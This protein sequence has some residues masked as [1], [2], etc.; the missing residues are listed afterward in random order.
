MK[1]IF[2]T[3]APGSKWS[4]VIKSVYFSPDIDR[5][6]HNV[7]REYLDAE[8]Q[9][10]HFGAYYDPGM[11]FG[12]FFDNLSSFSKQEC[13]NEFDKPFSGTGVR[14]IKSHS[15]AHHIDFLKDMWKDCP[16]LLVYRNDFDCLNWWFEAGGFDIT[17]PNYQWYRDVEFMKL[18]ISIQNQNIVRNTHSKISMTDNIHICNT[19]GIKNPE[20]LYYQSFINTDI[21]VKIIL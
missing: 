16:I 3:G 21:S 18:Q 12:N 7:Y 10:M 11:E 4:R 14:I 17:Y 1:Y 15:F 13:E 5:S 19:L 2:V 6:D 9:L 20:T 8:K